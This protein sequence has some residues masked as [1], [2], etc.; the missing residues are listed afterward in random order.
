MSVRRRT[1][2]G[3]QVRAAIVWVYTGC[4]NVSK[5]SGNAMQRNRGH[6]V[7]SDHIQEQIH[8]LNYRP[9]TLFQDPRATPAV[10]DFLRDTRVGR[11][12]GLEL[13]GIQE[14][15]LGRDIE[16]WTEDGAASD[17]DQEEEGGPGPPLRA[18]CI[19]PFVFF[20]LWLHIFQGKQ[21]RG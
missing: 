8:H 5:S 16:L 14:D 7:G 9:L 3:K 12:P 13:Y 20:P 1:R 4:D 15:E 21:G 17:E 10:L 6:E 11:M 19:F 18:L 2:E